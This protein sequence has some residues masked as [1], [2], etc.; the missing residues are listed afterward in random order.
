VALLAALTGSVAAAVAAGTLFVV[1]VPL[2]YFFGFPGSRGSRKHIILATGAAMLLS[3]AAIFAV[4]DLGP[5][6]SRL[7]SKSE[8]YQV[9]GS[10][11]RAP[12][13]RATWA[14]INDGG[15][16]G[17][18]WVGYGAGAFR[19]I[20]PPYQ[21]QQK[22]LQRDGKLF[23][24]AT[25]AHNDWLEM[26]ADWGVVGLLVVFTALLWLGRRLIRAFHGGHPETVPL[27][28][29]LLLLMAHASLDLL[30]WFTPLMFTAVFIGAAMTC[31]TDHSSIELEREL[32]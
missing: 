8:N 28:L 12:L 9:T 27:A 1:T 32:Y 4:A 22:E 18:A 11:D 30:F 20:S 21:A 16:K 23:Y 13:R 7:K 5:L 6:W 2:A 29:G 25:Y 14:L 24:R 3:A 15:W 10:D 19:W 17:R 31:L 26:L